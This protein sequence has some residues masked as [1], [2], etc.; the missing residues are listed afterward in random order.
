MNKETKNKIVPILR[1]A[2]FNNDGE[3]NLEPFSEVYSFKPTNSFSRD[4]LNYDI[5]TIKNIHYGD[6]HTKFSTLFDIE[7]ARVPFINP[8]LAIDNINLESYC[9]EGDIVLADASEDLK[10]VGKSIEIVNLNNERLLS[11]MH[12]ILARQKESKLIIGFGGHLFTSDGIRFQI[13]RESQGT[14]VLG[15]S[16]SR[17]RNI[18]IYYPKNKI[19][20]QKIADCLSSLDD[21][22][23][24]ENQR[25]EALKVHKKGLMQQLFPAEGETV[26]KLRFEEFRGSGEWEENSI[27][28]LVLQNILFAP[29]DGNHG[30][31]HPKSTDY[32][33]EGIPFIMASDLQN[34]KI[35]FSKCAYLRKEQAD[36]LQKGFAKEGDVLLSHK[37]TVGEVVILK[38]I[39]L[40][41]IMLTPQVTYYR[42]KDKSKLSNQF[43]ATFF[44]SELFQRKLKDAAGGGTRAYIGIL[45][46]GSLKIIVPYNILEQEKIADCLSSLDEL[47]A[48][49][50]EKIMEFNL[51]KKGLM[52]GLFPNTNTL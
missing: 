5:G 9:I 15:I 23:T 32:V 52:Q 49:Q 4:D 17:L 48:A 1:F 8:S 6:I 36:S 27:N 20:Q 38:K 13:Q 10:D 3:W 22:I 18:K 50:E 40:P 26:P 25:L 21:L 16:G 11:G 24:A 7:G 42:I 47:I 51:H 44:F 2:A 12:T 43:L 29:K 45:E 34:G 33:R 30:N 46:Q 31:L 37:G 19:E 28:E 41:Y 14:K 39:E 35:D